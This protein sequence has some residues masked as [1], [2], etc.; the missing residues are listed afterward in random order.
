M[1]ARAQLADAFHVAREIGDGA[2][3]R[4]AVIKET[5]GTAASAFATL[6]NITLKS[7]DFAVAIHGATHVGPNVDISLG[8]RACA[9]ARAKMPDVCNMKCVRATIRERRG[10]SNG[11]FD[12]PR[13]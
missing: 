13:V 5:R 12:A 7:I 9:S 4:R 8:C 10:V 3:A 2:M 6:A 1:L 11:V